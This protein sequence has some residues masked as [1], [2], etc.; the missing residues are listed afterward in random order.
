MQRVLVFSIL[1]SLIPGYSVAQSK[2]GNWQAYFLNAHVNDSPWRFVF[3]AQHRDYGLIGDLDHIIVR[4]GIQYFHTPTRSSYLAGYS[5]F[6]FQNEGDSN[7]TTLENRIFQDVDLRHSVGRV[8]LR[9]RY[10]AEERFVQNA[11]F[12]FRLRYAVFIDVPLNNKKI[13]AKT[14]Y[15]PIWNE[16]FIN[17][18]PIRFDRNWLYVGLG[19]QITDGFG[20]RL[21]AMDQFQTAG[22]KLQVVLSIHHNMIFKQE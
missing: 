8:L 9:H 3:D 6:L 2:L 7:N 14:W 4:P 19:Y 22:D 11:P 1:L 15:I 5:F 13:Q 18:D 17:T 20:V 10:R 12:A 16:V 21:G